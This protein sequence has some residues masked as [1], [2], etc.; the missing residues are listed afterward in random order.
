MPVFSPWHKLP[1]LRS[2]RP[3]KFCRNFGRFLITLLRIPA[4]PK[5]RLRSATRLLGFRTLSPQISLEFDNFPKKYRAKFR[6]NLGICPSRNFS[7]VSC[8]VSPYLLCLSLCLPICFCGFISIYFRLSV[9]PCVAQVVS[10]GV[11]TSLFL[12]V[13][14]VVS[15]CPCLSFVSIA[16]CFCVSLCL[17]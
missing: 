3:P 17:F 13:C 14:L 16:L 15:M 4:A 8:R 6:G 11:C 2:G 5:F 1:L 9:H 7:K 10:S 12:F